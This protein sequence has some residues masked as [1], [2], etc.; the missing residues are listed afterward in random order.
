VI[1]TVV[2]NGVLKIYYDNDSWKFWKNGE[3]KKLKAYV[4]VINPDGLDASAGSTVKIEGPV[5]SDKLNVEASSGA[6]MNGNLNVSTLNIDQSR[7]TLSIFRD[8]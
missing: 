3:N 4:S 7:G 2:E 8:Q 1:K 5:K 6:V